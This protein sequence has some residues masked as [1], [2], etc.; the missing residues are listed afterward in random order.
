[1]MMKFS[2]C[3]RKINKVSLPEIQGLHSNLVFQ[4]YLMCV[5]DLVLKEILHKMFN[6]VEN[7]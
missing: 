4:K 3:C 5:P 6:G 2:S 1:M 7:C